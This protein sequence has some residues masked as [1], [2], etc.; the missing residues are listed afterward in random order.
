MSPSL[1]LLVPSAA[2]LLEVFAVL[3]CGFLL[4]A[5]EGPAEQL[6]PVSLPLEEPLLQRGTQCL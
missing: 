4:A 3:L 2:E 6:H 5:A 1:G